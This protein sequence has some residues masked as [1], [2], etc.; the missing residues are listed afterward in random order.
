[1]S[2]T[3]SP[4]SVARWMLEQIEEHSVLDQASA[5]ADISGLFGDMFTME[6]D[7]GNLAISKEVLVA[8][9]KLTAENVVWDRNQRLWRKRESSDEPGRQQ[10]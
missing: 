9:R 7:C 3:H 8:F 2:Q 1:M 6:N 10:Q 5:V 4:E